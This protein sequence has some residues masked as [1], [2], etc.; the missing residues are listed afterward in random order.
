MTWQK[1][2]PWVIALHALAVGQ[3]HCFKAWHADPL[4]ATLA[5]PILSTRTWRT[6]PDSREADDGAIVHLVLGPRMCFI[7]INKLEL[8]YMQKDGASRIN[9]EDEKHK[10]VEDLSDTPKKGFYRV[11]VCL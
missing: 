4:P 7:C 6:L 8:K 2:H 10:K 11:D 5:K 1:R 9:N 3:K